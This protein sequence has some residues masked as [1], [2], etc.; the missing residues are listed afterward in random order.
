[1]PDYDDRNQ[2]TLNPVKD[3]KEDWHAD[4]A[5]SIN[6]EGKWFWLNANKRK[7][8]NGNFLSLKIGSEKKPKN[9]APK[10]EATRAATLDDFDDD[11]PF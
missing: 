1:M 2:G 7:G 3:K 8:T 6:I 5:G 11:L 4:F 9:E 10:T